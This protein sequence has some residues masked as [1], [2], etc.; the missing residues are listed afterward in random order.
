MTKLFYPALCAAVALLV[1]CSPH[2]GA[3]Y[4]SATGGGGEF[5]RLHVSYEGRTNIFGQQQ[6]EEEDS[7][8]TALRRC[9]W[10]GID[11]QTI[12]MTCV[13]AANTDIEERYR[14]QVE[15][16]RNRAELT[17]DG[18]QVASFVRKSTAK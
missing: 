13:L 8:A 12:E 4:W 2:P 14:L 3:G 17:R 10:R 6:A 15:A 18:K 7:D 16:D 1:G 9:F 11:A 5:A